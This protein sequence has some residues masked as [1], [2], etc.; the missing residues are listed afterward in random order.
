MRANKNKQYLASTV[1]VVVVTQVVFEVSVDGCCDGITWF[2][3][4]PLEDEENL[5]N[6]ILLL[7]L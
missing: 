7:V 4:T 6:A 5:A 3:K 1:A 2:G